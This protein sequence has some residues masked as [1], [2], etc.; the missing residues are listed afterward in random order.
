MLPRIEAGE[1]R[2]AIFDT[3]VATVNT[4]AEGR[5]AHFAALDRAIAGVAQPDARPAPAPTP[6]ALAAM[7]IAVIHPA[8]GSEAVGTS[9]GSEAVGQKGQS[10]SSEATGHN[11]V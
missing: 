5:D 8:P 2:A 9:S 6:E 3:A 10:S 4:S 11:D 1:R 7:G